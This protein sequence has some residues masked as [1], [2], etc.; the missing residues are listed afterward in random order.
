MGQRMGTVEWK[1]RVGDRVIV[2][3]D[4][5]GTAATISNLYLVGRH[6]VADLQSDGGP[7]P[8]V[9]VDSLEFT[10]TCVQY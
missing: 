8:G 9:R 10:G 4:D 2:Y 7:I 1:P 6:L 3:L 5:G